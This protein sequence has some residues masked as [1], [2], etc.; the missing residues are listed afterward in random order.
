MNES[1]RKDVWEA[2]LSLW[3]AGLVYGTQGN[4]SGM[5]RKERVVYIKP[6]GVAYEKLTES[7]IVKVDMEGIPVGKKTLKPS[8]DT[9]HHIFLY[10]NL[11]DISG[12]CHT[13]SKFITVFSILGIP[14]PV[15]TTAHAD[16]FGKEIPISE[17]ADNTGDKIGV[18]L[19]RLYKKT[20][21][22]AII[23]KKHGLFTLGET[24]SKSAF[25]ALMAEYCA[26]VSYYALIAGMATGKNIAPLDEKEIE[27]WYS[28]YHSSRYGQK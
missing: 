15:L 14:V 27:K 1:L 19:L 26:E 16:V 28:R 3:K 11:E 20:G 10:K 17:Y 23:L 18:E 24:P 4:V 9:I 8:V 2:N 21:C 6:S 22:P 7:M 25:Y 12:V 5:D 13:H